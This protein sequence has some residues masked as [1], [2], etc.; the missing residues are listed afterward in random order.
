M[1]RHPESQFVR[2]P[3][4]CSNSLQKRTRYVVAAVLVFA[5]LLGGI[6]APTV[7]QGQTGNFTYH[8]ENSIVPYD[9]LTGT[10]TFSVAPKISQSPND[11]NFPLETQGF[12]MVLVHDPT[13]LTPMN[14]DPSPLLATV[15]AGA[16]PDF[17]AATIIDNA[18]IVGV[19]YSFFGTDSLAFP[20][21]TPVLEVEYM[22][23]PAG[24]QGLAPPIT[25]SLTWTDGLAVDP[26]NHPVGNVV[27]TGGLSSAPAFDHGVITF[28]SDTTFVRGDINGSGSITMPDPLAILTYA[29]GS[30]SPNCLDAGD[31]DDNG[32]VNIADAILL[33]N[34]L[35]VPG[36]STPAAPFPDCGADITDDEVSCVSAGPC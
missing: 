33:F 6:A 18:F 22:T 11:P 26:N 30:T 27:T 9:P 4:S 19:V 25:T 12:S 34:Y 14:V 8:A 5:M 36:S 35:L 3:Q 28:V 1:A 10:G 15:N 7:A 20:I 31:V 32:R 13:M 16:A 24:F 29:F 17:Y 21:E 23:N 2:F